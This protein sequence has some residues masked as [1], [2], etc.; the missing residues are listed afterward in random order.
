MPIF[1][2]AGEVTHIVEACRNVTERKRAEDALEQERNLLRT[3]ID[4]LPDYIYV[5]DAQGRFIVANL[6]TALSWVRARRTISWEERMAIS[7][8]RSRRR[9]IVPTKKRSC[10]RGDRDQ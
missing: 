1:N 4:N 8:R 10:D 7:T 5:K 3:L 6:A 2:D 9:S